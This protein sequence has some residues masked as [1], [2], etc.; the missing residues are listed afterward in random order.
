MGRAAAAGRRLLVAP[1]NRVP[2]GRAAYARMSIG[3]AAKTAHFL[4]GR[5]A[6][7]PVMVD[8]GDAEVQS[9]LMKGSRED[10]P[11]FPVR[12]PVAF[13]WLSWRRWVT[14]PDPGP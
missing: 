14:A 11:T 13:G 12:K 6:N 7:R 3:E 4:K 9:P 2:A 1:G 8:I 5:W 10:A